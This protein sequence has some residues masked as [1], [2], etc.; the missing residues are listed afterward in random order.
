MDASQG[1]HSRKS[2]CQLS[3]GS[4]EL[5]EVESAADTGIVIC[6]GVAIL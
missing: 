2:G 1:F 6:M 5:R 3:C 4:S